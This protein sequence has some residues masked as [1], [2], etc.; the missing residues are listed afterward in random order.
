M[1]PHLMIGITRNFSVSYQLGDTA[2]VSGFETLLPAQFQ[3]F[4][5]VHDGKLPLI[6]LDYTEYE[7]GST[8][9]TELEVTALLALDGFAVPLARVVRKLWR[10]S[11]GNYDP[12]CE[13]F[14]YY[15]I[16][17][18]RGLSVKHGRIS[19]GEGVYKYS[20]NINCEQSKLV[21][22][23]AGGHYE[24]RDYLLIRQ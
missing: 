20:S 3:S 21:Q 13:D 16:D 8:G 15:S 18:S 7:Q 19:I 6:A 14:Q 2:R 22:M 4:R 12:A 1:G 23:L 10:N 5:L 24:V 11:Q 9:N 17:F